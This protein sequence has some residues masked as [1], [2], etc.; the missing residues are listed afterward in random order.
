M[1]VEQNVAGPI[2]CLDLGTKHV[3]VAI[4]DP[5]LIAITTVKA[6][7]RSSW[8]QLLRDIGDLVRRFDARTMVIG[9]PLRLDASEGSAAE[10]VRRMA[11]KFA[12]SLEIPIFLQ[13][14][15]LTS[16]EAEENLRAKGYD[17]A[18]V[19]A[20]VDSEAAAIILRDFITAGQQR[21]PIRRP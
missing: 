1:M 11:E 17:R 3:G 14:E 19:A 16:V 20:R 7:R 2:L 13:D 21:I 4:S 18:E 9:F 10:E 12:R 8:K 15:R 5:T 6:L